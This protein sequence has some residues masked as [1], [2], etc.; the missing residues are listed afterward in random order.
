M[1]FKHIHFILNPAAGSEEPILS[2]INQVFC[3]SGIKW[4]I[5]VTRKN[6][7]IS[8]TAKAL[9]GKTDLVAVYGG[10]G[11]VA[12]VAYGLYGSDTPMG[13]I[14]GG[15]ANVMAKELK[16]PLETLAAL[17]VFKSGA[18]KVIKIDMGMVNKYPFILRINLGLM[19]DMILKADRKLKDNLGQ[20]AYG[21]SALTS[22]I[23]AEQVK[24]KLMID[25]KRIDESG[26]SLTVTNSGSIGIGSFELLPGISI[27]DGLL[28]VILLNDASLLSVLKVAGT[29]LFKNDSSVLKHWK[30]REVVI[31]MDTAVSYICDDTE[32]K[33]KRLRIKVLPNALKVVIPASL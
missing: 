15:T 21:V 1:K 28:D 25:G 24:Y 3:Q 17:E 19:A 11:S 14:P 13:I 29:T 30:C 12:D 8:K 5:T 22:L 10:D 9:I 2:H 7:N 27:T 26:V 23:K 16:I 33:A 6:E 4:D 20:L 18:A 31:S 32:R